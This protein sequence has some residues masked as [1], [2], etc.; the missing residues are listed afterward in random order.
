MC[1]F[2]LVSFPDWQFAVEDQ[3]ADGDKVT[4]RWT[5]KATHSGLLEGIAPTGK[6][7]AVTGILISRLEDG[8]MVEDWENFDE[9]GMMRQVGALPPV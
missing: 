5:A 2:Y 6:A 1:E 4:T 7:L 8:K 3:V 9:F